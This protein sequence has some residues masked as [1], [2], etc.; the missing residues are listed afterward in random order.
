MSTEAKPLGGLR[1]LVPRGGTWGDLVAK[2]LREQGAHTVI[3][4]LVDFA[5]TS[6]E[7]KLVEAL[8]ELE[9]GRFDWMTATSATVAD[10]L[11]HHDA[12]IPPETKVAIVGEATA[13]AFRDAGYHVTR[14]PEHENS[15]H[16]L[17]E[18][19]PE[20]DSGEV[21]R[22]LTVRSDVAVPVLTE[23]LMSRGHDVTQV[24]AFRTVGVPASVHIR[25]D[26]ESG[27]INALVVASAKI[28]EQVAEQFPEVPDDTIFAC[29]GVN[30][31]EAAAAVGL[32]TEGDAPGHPLY[33]KKRALIETVESVIDQSDMLD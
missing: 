33:E 5:H 7:D 26:I 3:A 17:L 11:K 22:V 13:V 32:P 18:E 12:V 23:G 27:R 8:K 29:V 10:V 20:I 25:E 14:T 31:L 24:L 30:T 4:P 15:T 19:W 9:A 1:V 21:L 6:E 28:A 2:A 16:A